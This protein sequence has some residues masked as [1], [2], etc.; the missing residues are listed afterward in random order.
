MEEEEGEDVAGKQAPAAT[1]L[2]VTRC[3]DLHGADLVT[4]QPDV[5]GSTPRVATAGR[6]SPVGAAAGS[7][8]R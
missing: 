1:D 7:L 8:A 3:L 6:S 5:L 4:D 2:D